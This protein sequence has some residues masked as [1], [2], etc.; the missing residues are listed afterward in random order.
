MSLKG[1]SNKPIFDEACPKG[2]KKP[3]CSMRQDA[4][5]PAHSRCRWPT[6]GFQL[7]I[8]YVYNRGSRH[9]WMNSK[10]RHFIHCIEVP[11]KKKQVDVYGRMKLC[12]L[13]YRY[14]QK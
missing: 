10:K 8:G 7:A 6:L 12:S 11:T 4:S 9:A 5:D 14:N 3:I 1:G 13:L 2:H